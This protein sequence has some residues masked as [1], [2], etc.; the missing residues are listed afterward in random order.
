MLLAE[1]EEEG[2]LPQ[3]SFSGHSDGGKESSLV[4]QSGRSITQAVRLSSA[5]DPGSLKANS[6][7]VCRALARTYVAWI[8]P[9]SSE[10][11]S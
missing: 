9:F 7:L 4:S 5:E 8:C 1:G 2:Q 6:F 3:A 10:K 11:P